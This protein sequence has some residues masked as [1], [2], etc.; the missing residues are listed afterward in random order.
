MARPSALSKPT[1]KPTTAPKRGQPAELM[2]ALTKK[3][4]QPAGSTTTTTK[5]AKKS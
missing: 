5:Q 2:A 1:A 4:G 3:R